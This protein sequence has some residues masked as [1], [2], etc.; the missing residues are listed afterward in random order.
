MNTNNKDKKTEISKIPP[1]ILLRLSKKIFKKLKFY[2]EKGKIT[3]KQVYIQN[4]QS[5]T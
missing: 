2:K 3:N 4:E 1:S 5:Y